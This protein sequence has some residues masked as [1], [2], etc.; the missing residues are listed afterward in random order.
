MHQYGIAIDKMGLKPR[1]K[2]DGF[3][4]EHSDPQKISTL[5]APLALGD[6]KRTETEGKTTTGASA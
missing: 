5:S 4:L 6:F 1:H 3:V 2:L